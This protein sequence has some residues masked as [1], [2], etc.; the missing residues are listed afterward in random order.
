MII[1]ISKRA[2]TPIEKIRSLDVLKFIQK[3]NLNID[4]PVLWSDYSFK[5]GYMDGI[6]LKSQ[7]IIHYKNNESVAQRNIQLLKQLNI[8]EAEIFFITGIHSISSL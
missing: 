4:I 2:L 1:D 6:V 5:F 3:Y 7:N 8:P